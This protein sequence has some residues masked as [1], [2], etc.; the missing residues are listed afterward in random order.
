M[1]WHPPEMPAEV[2]RTEPRSHRS[3]GFFTRGFALGSI[4]TRF[5]SIGATVLAVAKESLWIQLAV[6]DESSLVLLAV[7]IESL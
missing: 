6:A 7:A 2:S 1:R 5:F 3:R 4:V